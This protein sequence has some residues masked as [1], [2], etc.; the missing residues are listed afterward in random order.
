MVLTF[1]VMPGFSQKISSL[2]D[3]QAFVGKKSSGMNKIAKEYGFRKTDDDLREEGYLIWHPFSKTVNADGDEI[4][5]ELAVDN[6]EKM[7]VAITIEDFDENT[8]PALLNEL[9]AAG[10]KKKE[11]SK[12]LVNVGAERADL[13]ISKD[14]QWRVLVEYNA[15]FGK[16]KPN[17]ITYSYKFEYN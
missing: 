17:S 5:I 12:M 14:G 8:Y 16:E 4:Y 11:D 6:D 10:Y 15:L 9:K 2:K 1:F 7:I 3:L 13:W